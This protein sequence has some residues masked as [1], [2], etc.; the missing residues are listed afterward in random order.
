MFSDLG[1]KAVITVEE[2]TDWN[3]AAVFVGKGTIE[4]YTTKQERRIEISTDRDGNIISILYPAYPEDYAYYSEF[5]L[6]QKA[7]EYG[8][9]MDEIWRKAIDS[10]ILRF[11]YVCKAQEENQAKGK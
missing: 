6:W 7:I 3:G 9:I 11:Y 4:G 5:P 8:R 10:L 1:L 2:K